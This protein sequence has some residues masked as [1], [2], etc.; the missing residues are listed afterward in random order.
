MAVLEDGKVIFRPE[1]DS[2]CF[3]QTSWYWVDFFAPTEA[4]VAHLS[5]YFNFHSL[6]IEDCLYMLQR[7]K[8]D[9]YEDYRFFVLHSFDDTIKQP[10][11]VN[12]FQN[13]NFIVTF[14]N[15][16]SPTIE[17]IREQYKQQPTR[18]EKGTNYLLYLILY[19]IVDSYSPIL[20]RIEDELEKIESDYFVQLDQQ[21]INRIFKIRKELLTLRR[22]L[23][24]MRDVLKAIM[25]PEEDKWK[26]R[27]KAFFS[28]ILDSITRLLE[29]TEVY[30][31]IGMDLIES[32]VS[33]NSQKANQVMVMLTVI[34][35]IF[36]PLT[37]IVGV[38]GMNFNNMPELRWHNGYYYSLLFM[39]LVAGIMI[40]WIKRKNWF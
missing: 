21:T 23:D 22:S 17:Q 20:A 33:I 29:L 19:G 5:C 28:D 1:F 8:V 9:N 24:P 16:P 7:P 2:S 36:M 25:H 10:D 40:L 13:N 4:E 18:A 34:A 14:H 6:A 26:N 39:A 15:E 38:Y 12:L 30:R 27:H 37:F 3:H 35:T 32:H 11:E 31:Q